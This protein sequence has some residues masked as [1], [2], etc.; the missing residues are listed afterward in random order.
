MGNMVPFLEQL[1]SDWE[2]IRQQIA[3]MD[4]IRE[5]VAAEGRAKALPKIIY[6]ARN[7][8][9]KTSRSLMGWETNKKTVRTFTL[10]MV[11]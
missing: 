4:D 8:L 1:P 3:Q 7:F 10:L 5:I 2:A 11:K 6:Q 9:F